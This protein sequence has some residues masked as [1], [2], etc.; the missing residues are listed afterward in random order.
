MKKRQLASCFFFFLSMVAGDLFGQEGSDILGTWYNTEKTAQV[1]ISREGSE[2]VGRILQVNR[3]AEEKETIT[4][5][6]NPDAKLRDRPLVGLAILNGLSFED[7][8]W[9]G[10]TI[11]DPESGK[12]YSCQLKLKGKDVL[13]VKG[14]VGFSWIGRTVEWTRVKK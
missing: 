11:Y 13:E 12:T 8:M 10:G 9:K 6:Q 5:K 3:Q 1:E 7:G 2:F 4:D 14:F